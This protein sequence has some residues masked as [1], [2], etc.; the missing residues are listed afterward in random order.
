M[1][2]GLMELYTPSYSWQKG[3]AFA[4]HD[5]DHR[6]QVEDQIETGKYWYKWAVGAYVIKEG[7]KITHH[8]VVWVSNKKDSAYTAILEPPP[9]WRFQDPRELQVQ[10]IIGECDQDVYIDT[11][12]MSVKGQYKAYN[13]TSSKDMTS[14][15]GIKLVAG[16]TQKY[17]SF[18]LKWQKEPKEAGASESTSK[19]YWH[20]A[21][22]SFV[23]EGM[24]TLTEIE[25]GQHLT[26]V[27][28]QDSEAMAYIG[29]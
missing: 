22:T 20:I 15:R 9:D 7:T 5:T 6:S 11:F 28:P 24:D 13:S 21:H 26:A 27:V 10:F 8:D 2:T 18:T 16:R 3:R 29:G 14:E 17:D 23:E 19:A 12:N 4:I 1:S 25:K